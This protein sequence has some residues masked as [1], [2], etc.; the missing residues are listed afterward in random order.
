MKNILIMYNAGPTVIIRQTEKETD[1]SQKHAARQENWLIHL[2]HNFYDYII[3]INTYKNN[4]RKKK[5]IIS[6]TSE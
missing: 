5:Y 3:L 1:V 4:K 6:K 2:V